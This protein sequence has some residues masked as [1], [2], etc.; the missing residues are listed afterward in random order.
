[1]LPLDVA[2]EVAAALAVGAPVVALESTLVAHGLPY[3]DNLEVAHELEATVRAGGATPATIA[4]VAG[5]VRIGL[6]AAALA[7]LAAD[8]VRFAKAGAA[9]LAVHLAR[10]GDAATTV[11]A[12]AVLARRA[13]IRVFA[14]GGIG[15][16]HRGDSGD[17]S[18]DL[19]AL[20]RTPIAVVSAGAK[21][22]LDLPR[23]LE[24]LEAL[25][26][27]VVGHRTDELPAFYT[28]SSGLRLDHRVDDVATLA[29]IC[30]ARWDGLGQGG[31]LVCNPIPAAAALDEATIGAAIEAAVADARAEAVSGKRL[32]P[33]LLARL[34]RATGGAAV[35]AN[36]ALV[37]H[38]AA[39]AAELAVAL[40]ATS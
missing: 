11:S 22:I 7:T 14:T 36:R 33:F 29:A 27:L 30:R 23:T 39:V 17:V 10:G 6:P 38:D 21:A 28:R 20:A 16:V 32:T 24:Q 8:G 25:G 1:M 35:A 34:A 4:V 3:P 18:H 5:R 15:G 26:V 31:V 13:G 2:P 12:T 19:L 9:D 40:A 37:R